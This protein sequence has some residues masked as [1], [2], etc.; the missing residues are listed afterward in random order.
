MSA[1]N[2]SDDS[3]MALYYGVFGIINMALCLVGL[4]LLLPIASNRATNVA[5]I[6]GCCWSGASLL[7]CGISAVSESTE[8]LNIAQWGIT[9]AAS[10]VWCYIYSV[11]L[12]NNRLDAAIVSWIGLLVVA[13]MIGPVFSFQTIW[14][15]GMAD[16]SES[17]YSRFYFLFWIIFWI[18]LIIAY[19]K[20]ARSGA[21]A[22]ACDRSPAPE[23]AYT[24]LNKYMAGIFI[25]AGVV[26]AVLWAMYHFAAP[27]LRE[28]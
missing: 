9:V 16:W 17:L 23:G 14:M 19:F 28:L 8:G 18:L 27:V 25:T 15:E 2:V 22:G 4:L 24:P 13:Q 5:L 21:F 20:F 12:R 26:I 10:I 11:I 7:F 3:S 6:V 1:L